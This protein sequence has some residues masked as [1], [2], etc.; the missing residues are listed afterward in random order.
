MEHWRRQ[1]DKCRILFAIEHLGR[2]AS[3]FRGNLR[4]SKNHFKFQNTNP[5]IDS[6]SIGFQRHFQF[7]TRIRTVHMFYQGSTRRITTSLTEH[8]TRVKSVTVGGDDAYRSTF[9]TRMRSQAVP[10]E[11]VVFAFVACLLGSDKDFLADRR[12]TGCAAICG[13]LTRG[14]R[15]GLCER[16]ANDAQWR[17]F[18]QRSGTKFFENAILLTFLDTYYSETRSMTRYFHASMVSSDIDS[19]RFDCILQNYAAKDCFRF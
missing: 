2:I 3:S 5:P 13:N 15:E 17:V 6:G 9:G 1:N 10:A 12:Q 16:V 7:I 4:P 14:L 8:S 11:F 19:R 18:I